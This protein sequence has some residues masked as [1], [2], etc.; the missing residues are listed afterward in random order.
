MEKVL[1]TLIVDDH[2]G[3]RTTLQDIL[4]DEGYHVISASSGDEAVEICQD[5]KFDIIIMD[6][7]MPGINGVEAFRRI[8]AISKDTRVIM[9][10]AYSI[11]EMKLEALREGAIAFLQKPLD[12]SQVLRLIEEDDNTPVLVVMQDQQ[13]REKI[14]NVLEKKMYRTHLT[15]SPDEAMELARQIRFKLIM[16]ETKLNPITGLELY[17]ALKQISPNIVT[18]ILADKE[19]KFIKQAK[20]AV[21]NN[22]YT[23]LKK[24]LQ[25]DTLVS[26]LDSLKKQLNSDIIDKPGIQE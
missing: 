12:I 26:L 23:F 16:I 17:L 1:R 20:E 15:H 18:I 10:S 25:S 3:M 5:I 24:P 8:K 19:D 9:M 21:E 7:K 4:E 2:V 11:D 6:V 13:E 14:L 22:A